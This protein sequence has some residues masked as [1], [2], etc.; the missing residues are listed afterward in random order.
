MLRKI[1]LNVEVP[2][3]IGISWPYKMVLSMEKAMD[4]NITK[5]TVEGAQLAQN[6]LWKMMEEGIYPWVAVKPA[7]RNLEIYQT[8]GL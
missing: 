8:D 1:R 2:L 3:A 4:T 5:T 7:T 6:Y